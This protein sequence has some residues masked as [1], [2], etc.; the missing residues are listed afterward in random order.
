MPLKSFRSSCKNFGT[1]TSWMARRQ[2]S[3]WETERLRKFRRNSICSEES[4][5]V[6]VIFLESTLASLKPNEY[7]EISA[8]MA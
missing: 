1:L 4:L 3:S 8:I 5:K 2:I 7:K 6:E